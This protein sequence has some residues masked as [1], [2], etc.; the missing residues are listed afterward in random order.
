MQ[1]TIPSPPAAAAQPVC[2]ACLG[3]Q[4]DPATRTTCLRCCGTGIDPDP[5]APANVIPLPARSAL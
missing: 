4:L 1:N 3:D 5:Q 2:V